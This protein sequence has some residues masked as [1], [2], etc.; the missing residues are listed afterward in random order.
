M[1]YPHTFLMKKIREA[2]EENRMLKGA[3]NPYRSSFGRKED[4]PEEADEDVK[5][6]KREVSGE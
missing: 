1:R 4:A 2:L 3:A 5:K 6:F